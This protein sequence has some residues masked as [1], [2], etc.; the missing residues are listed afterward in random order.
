MNKSQSPAETNKKTKE[1][2]NM[3][4]NRQGL[5]NQ[6]EITKAQNAMNQGA[7]GQAMQQQF[8]GMQSGGMVK[9]GDKVEAQNAMQ[10]MQS[11]GMV[12]PGDKIEAKSQM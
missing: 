10:G 11:G 6:E 2:S 5:L 9:P 4:Q 8:T 7:T 12:K 3:T 1:S